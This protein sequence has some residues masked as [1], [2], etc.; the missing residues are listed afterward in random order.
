MLDNLGLRPLKHQLSCLHEHSPP[1][2]AVSSL[3]T[4][5]LDQDLLKG[6]QPAYDP[7]LWFG[8]CIPL[9]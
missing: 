5:G 6:T 2:T 8:H 9:V 3:P 1:D 7:P 4:G